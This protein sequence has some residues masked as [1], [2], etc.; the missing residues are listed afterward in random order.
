[1]EFSISIGLLQQALKVMTT[2]TKPNKEDA[3]GHVLIDA[4]EDGIIF[5][6]Y[7]G[8]LSATHKVSEFNIKSTGKVCVP[9]AKLL[10]FINSF[11]SWDGNS[12]VEEV[13]LKKLKSTTSVR[14]VNKFDNGNAAKNKLELRLF[15]TK[16]FHIPDPFNETTFSI[17]GSVLK[18]AI[19][20]VVYSLDVNS[21]QSF[22][23]GMN[24]LFDKDYIYFAGTNGAKLSEYRAKNVGTQKEG[25]LIIH[26]TFITALRKLTDITDV[27][28]FEVDNNKIRAVIGT[29]TLHSPLIIDNPYPNY[30][31]MFDNYEHSIKLDKEILLNSFIP[32]LNV[33]DKEDHNRLTIEI[34]NKKLTITSTYSES[35]YG[36]D[37]DFDLDFVVDVNGYFMAQTLDAIQDDIVELKFTQDGS[38]IIFDSSNFKD[39][40]SLITSIKRR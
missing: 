6:G 10:S 39:Q 27:V 21:P 5:V 17:P 9:F 7:D 22:I 15:P 13:T 31:G 20:K 29:T 18:I 24:V 36:G 12:G 37:I 11:Y 38:T 32:Y 28:Y 1:M 40:K 19:A 35:D 4:S 34:K 25:S 23:Q 16:K 30:R 26:Y 2:V 33:L 8:M 3:T 14:L